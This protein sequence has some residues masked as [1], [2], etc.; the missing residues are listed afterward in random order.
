MHADLHGAASVIIKNNDMTKPIPPLTLFQAGQACVCRSAAWSAKIVASAWWVHPEQVSK[1]APTGEYLTTGSFIIRGRKNYLPPQ[2]LVMGLGFLFRLDESCIAGHLG[3]RAPRGLG[4]DEDEGGGVSTAGTSSRQQTNAAAMLAAMNLQDDDDVETTKSGNN[5]EKGGG[6]KDSYEAFMEASYDNA[7]ALASKGRQDSNS[8]DAVYE[9]YGLENAPSGSGGGATAT[10]NKQQK[11]A[12]LEIEDDDD[13]IASRLI[14]ESSSKGGG[15]RR[16]LSAKERQLRKKGISIVGPEAE[17]SGLLPGKSK[18]GGGGGGASTVDL[19]DKPQQYQ[20]AR[21][22]N[23]KGK[24]VKQRYQDQDEEDREIAMQLLQPAGQKKDRKQRKA[25][26]KERMAARKA[27]Q[28]GL[29]QREL[30]EEEI[31]ALTAKPSQTLNEKES[32]S[33]SDDSDDN[34]EGQGTEQSIQKEGEASAKGTETTGDDGHVVTEQQVRTEKGVGDNQHT[35]DDNDDDDDSQEAEDD[36]EDTK[37]DGEEAM[38]ASDD[39]DEEIA[40]LL[41][42]E[43]IVLLGEGQKV[44]PL[45][46]LTG[47]PREGDTLMYAIPVCAPYAVLGNYKHRVK[48]VP[49]PLKKGKAGRQCVELLMREAAGR[50]KDLIKGVPEQELINAVVGGVRLQVAGLQKLQKIQRGQKKKKK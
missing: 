9:R 8:I 49:G 42:S 26:R 32:D 6:P 44:S 19:G 11:H 25:E 27:V 46:A 14:G 18:K 15:N 40:A 3:E 1:T 24:K 10:N 5:N 43:N 2:P 31:A 28:T 41:A 33:S 13:D 50:E 29:P 47:C 20:K 39:E 4:D 21:G 30:T 36:N 16:H 7:T 23:A 22:K 34:S 45:D 48:L 17:I 38:V 35:S 12:V 37:D